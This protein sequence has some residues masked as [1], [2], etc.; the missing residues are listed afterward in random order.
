M[1]IVPSV[2]KY[3]RLN[4]ASGEKKISK[5]QQ[6]NGKRPPRRPENYQWLQGK[7][8]SKLNRYIAELHLYGRP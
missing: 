6:Q 4:R 8:S 7:F 3:S 5:Q 2:K 1:C